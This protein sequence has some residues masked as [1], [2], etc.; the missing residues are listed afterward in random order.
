M[1]VWLD[2]ISTDYGLMSLIVIAVMVVAML[3]FAYYVVKH[4]GK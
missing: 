4:I 3:G 2:L 1:K